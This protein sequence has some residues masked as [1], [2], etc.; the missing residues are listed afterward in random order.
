MSPRDIAKV[1]KESVQESHAVQNNAIIIMTFFSL[2]QKKI[3]IPALSVF[4]Y[5]FSIK[6]LVGR[7][8][9]YKTFAFECM[10]ILSPETL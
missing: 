10:T 6:V 5:L 8:S 2:L 3:L 9:K 1:W 7:Q 4:C